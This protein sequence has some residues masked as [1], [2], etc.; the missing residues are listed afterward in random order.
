[1]RILHSSQRRTGLSAESI[2]RTGTACGPGSRHLLQSFRSFPLHRSGHAASTPL[3][4]GAY[5][6]AD[7]YLDL[8][9]RFRTSKRW[10]VADSDV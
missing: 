2:K 5:E 9:H 6:C 4:A 3:P 7:Q 1:M 10:T 8:G